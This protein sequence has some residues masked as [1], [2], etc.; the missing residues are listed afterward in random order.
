MWACVCVCVWES[1]YVG[2]EGGAAGLAGAGVVTVVWALH[3]IVI[4]DLRGVCVG[5]SALHYIVIR[6][7]RGV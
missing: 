1:V 4:R 3:Y 5:V 2:G 6:D 7:L